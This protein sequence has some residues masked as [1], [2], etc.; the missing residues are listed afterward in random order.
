MDISVNVIYHFIG[1][2]L[3]H[4]IWTSR[5]WYKDFMKCYKKIGF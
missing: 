4:Q 1:E 2:H 3:V 5:D